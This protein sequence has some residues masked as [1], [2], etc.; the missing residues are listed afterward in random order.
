MVKFRRFKNM[1][2]Q[3]EI[4][5]KINNVDQ[6]EWFN[7]FESRYND[8][9]ITKGN[10]EYKFRAI[11]LEEIYFFNASL[12][13]LFDNPLFKEETIVKNDI[14]FVLNDFNDNVFF[15]TVNIKLD[16]D[17][18]L[19]LGKDK[20]DFTFSEIDLT[21]DY[22][23]KKIKQSTTKVTTTP[24]SFANSY[25]LNKFNNLNKK[26]RLTDDEFM[27]R[28]ALLLKLGKHKQ[29]KVFGEYDVVCQYVK[30][31][32]LMNKAVSISLNQDEVL[33]LIDDLTLKYEEELKRVKGFGKY[34]LIDKKIPIRFSESYGAHADPTYA[35]SKL[36]EF[37]DW[38]ISKYQEWS[39]ETIFHEFVHCLGF[40]TT[41]YTNMDA[42]TEF[43]VVRLEEVLNDYRDW[44]E[45]RFDYEYHCSQI[46]DNSSNYIIWI[47]TNEQLKKK[48]YKKQQENKNIEKELD[49]NYF[50]EQGY[51]EDEFPIDVIL[52]NNKE[53]LIDYLIFSIN[54]YKK[55]VNNKYEVNQI[56][57][58]LKD[59]REF[60]TFSN[61]QLKMILDTLKVRY[62]GFF[63]DKDIM[64][65]SILNAEIDAFIPKLESLSMG[66]ISQNI[67]LNKRKILRGDRS[68]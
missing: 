47:A 45:E 40:N 18:I 64:I 31:P 51:A 6:Q 55:T 16:T 17:N 29:K 37:G 25:E 63:K 34:F 2:N 14:A 38:R 1:E 54:E 68:K 26:G 32:V 13:S 60:S 20:T 57:K 5:A 50:Q 19:E 65:D 24:K 58:I 39:A 66:I 12:V 36:C 42:H 33:E 30:N 56:V 62:R 9:N 23:I 61:S 43:F 49:K 27:K 41:S 21:Y 10:I 3:I 4:I 46:I 8:G 35:E 15:G 7:L 11:F 44:I 59:D 52:I 28:L 53:E 48:E 22:F 67:D